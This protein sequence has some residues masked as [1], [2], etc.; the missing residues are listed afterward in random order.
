MS[1]YCDVPD[2]IEKIVTYIMKRNNNLWRTENGNQ[3]GVNGSCSKI[4][5]QEVNTDTVITMTLEK[6]G[7]FLRIQWITTKQAEQRTREHR[8]KKQENK[9]LHFYREEAKSQISDTQANRWQEHLD[10]VYA[11]V[12]VQHNR[13]NVKQSSNPQ[14]TEEIAA[15]LSA[16]SKY[17]TRPVWYRTRSEIPDL[18]LDTSDMLDS[19]ER[20]W[21]KNRKP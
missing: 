20:L 17:R 9:T 5:H 8:T 14:T 2:G 1:I 15:E 16:V 7:Y 3:R 21:E 12:E 10:R 19:T 11:T 13:R 6:G 18:I 4:K